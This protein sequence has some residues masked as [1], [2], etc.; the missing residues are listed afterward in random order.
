MQCGTGGGRIKKAERARSGGQAAGWAWCRFVES[1][2]PGHQQDSARTCCTCRH[3]F[4]RLHRPCRASAAS[5]TARHLARR[6]HERRDI[7][8]DAV[9]TRCCQLTPTPVSGCAAWSHIWLRVV[10]LLRASQPPV[11]TFVRVRQGGASDQPASAPSSH[12]IL[13]PDSAHQRSAK[14]DSRR[15]ASCM[16]NRIIASASGT[17]LPRMARRLHSGRRSQSRIRRRFRL[18]LRV[19]TGPYARLRQGF[20]FRLL[21]A[22][23]SASQ[24][25]GT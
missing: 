16:Y 17:L 23:R 9:C 19:A 14:L 2:R 5:G 7:T 21:S 12:S 6:T 24:P 8:G 11:S 1:V 4:G 13:S 25:H 18:C 20:S 15:I 22:T 3:P 10:L